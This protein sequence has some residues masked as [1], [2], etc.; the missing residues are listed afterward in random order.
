MI[1]QDKRTPG[2]PAL[3]ADVVVF[4]EALVDLF[5]ED[6][7]DLERAARFARH[8]GGAGA[9]LAV[10]LRR[11]GVPS[12][13]V[14]QV[15]ADAMGRFLLQRLRDEGVAT[16]GL[17]LHPRARTGVVFIAPAGPS[18]LAY[19]GP[20]ADMLAGEV[21]PP[22]LTRGRA[23]ALGSSTLICEP[24]RAATFRACEVA[25][26]AGMLIFVDLNFRPHLWGD[27]R[28]AAP[29]LRR[30]C[31][32]ADV[33]K[34]AEGELLPLCGTESPEEAAARVRALGP[35]VVAITRGAMGCALSSPAGEAYFAAEPVRVVDATGAG[36]AF[37]AG[38][39]AGLLRELTP[40]GQRGQGP[41]EGLAALQIAAVKRAGAAA[42]HLG[43][44]ACTARG[45][46]GA[47]QALRREQPG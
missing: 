13:L 20:S 36:D 14:G 8:L 3:P 46:T 30:L 5:A 44:V 19:R 23:L 43:A 9:N 10:W 41:R 22:H 31:A 40:L 34:L 29:L 6:G 45:A 39:L 38:L 16:D 26:K 33:V 15:G 28:G 17:V 18:F 24:A 42:V 7:L 25:R 21:A 35:Q 37:S 47:G 12:A 2:G 1:A 11:Q 27:A 4:G 32:A